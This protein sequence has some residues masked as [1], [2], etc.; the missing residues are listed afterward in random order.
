MEKLLTMRELVRFTGLPHG[1]LRHW[2]DRGQ[3]PKAV[4]TPGGHRRFRMIDVIDWHNNLY[5][6]DKPGR[7]S[8]A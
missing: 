6:Q 3:G 4:W 2:L 5:K 7:Q 1:T 8:A